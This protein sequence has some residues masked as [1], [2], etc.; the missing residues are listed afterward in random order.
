M[1]P[2]RALGRHQGA[3]SPDC[4]HWIVVNHAAVP[5]YQLALGTVQHRGAAAGGATTASEASGGEFLPL[6]AVEAVAAVT[7]ALLFADLFGGV[8]LGRG[9]VPRPGRR[10]ALADGV[11]DRHFGGGRRGAGAGACEQLEPRQ[12]DARAKRLI[13]P[14]DPEA[15]CGSLRKY[16]AGALDRRC[17]SCRDR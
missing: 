5:R 4:R 10:L 12:D 16:P 17:R 1:P 8:G 15:R 3:R 2:P 13:L 9:P 6:L 11:P 14:H 7:T